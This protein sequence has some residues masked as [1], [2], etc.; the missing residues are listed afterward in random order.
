MSKRR[1]YSPKFKER[2]ARAA[3]EGGATIAE[4]AHRF[5]VHPNLIAQW[6]RK[7]LDHLP[8]ACDTGRAP[9]V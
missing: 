4:L 9:S 3:I 1:N 8:D 7:A 2:I 5:E 6:K